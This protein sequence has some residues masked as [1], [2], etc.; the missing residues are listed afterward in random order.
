[1]R[2]SELLDLIAG[3]ED[4][5]LEFKRD[6]IRNDQLAKELVAFLNLEGGAVLLGVEDDGA[7]S[8]T[9]RV[10]VGRRCAP[11]ARRSCEG[12]QGGVTSMTTTAARRRSTSFS[13]PSR[14]SR[15]SSG[16]P[17]G[18]PSAAGAV[19]FGPNHNTK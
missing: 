10:G 9:R 14:R 17:G 3:G 19:R 16:V 12:V 13:P 4:S 18:P 6:A 5:G 7:V 15:N 8:G 2:R 11:K 1:M